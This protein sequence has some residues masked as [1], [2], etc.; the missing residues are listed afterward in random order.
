M[1]TKF[2]ISFN[3]VEL[4]SDPET[5][6]RAQE[7]G[8][9]GGMAQRGVAFFGEKVAAGRGEGRQLLQR[10][11]KRAAASLALYKSLLSR[12]LIFSCLLAVSLLCC[13]A[14]FFSS[15]W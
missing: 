1:L 3:F 4:L 8:R 7:S 11:R 6:P 10:A 9:V 5:F 12:L 2:L 13:A 14:C 15:R